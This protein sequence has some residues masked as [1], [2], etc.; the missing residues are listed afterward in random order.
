MGAKRALGSWVVVAGL[1]VTASSNAAEPDGS[2]APE[3]APAEGDAEMAHP[4]PYYWGESRFFAAGEIDLGVLYFRPR[5]SLGYGQPFRQWAGIDANPLISTDGPGVYSGLRFEMPFGDL[6]VGA[7]VRATFDRS[8]L[9]PQQ[10]YDVEDIESRVGPR[11]QYV[12]WESQFTTGIPVGPGG[13]LM[14]LTGTAVTEVDKGYF[15]FEETLRAVIDPPWA[16]RGRLGYG[17]RFIDGRLRITPVAEILHMPARSAYMLRGG[18]LA[19]FRVFESLDVRV[20]SVPTLYS[21][22]KLGT[23]GADT[24]LAGI[25]WRWASG[26]RRLWQAPAPPR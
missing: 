15:V 5:L 8:F 21:R 3:P 7:R 6:R 13:I 9:V 16:W 11:S 25:R 14:E 10:E 26:R 20:T 17:V 19:S 24:L 4:S 2:T 1:L 18:L 23:E 22:D 12:S